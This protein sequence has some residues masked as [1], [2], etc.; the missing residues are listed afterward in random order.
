ML[1]PNVTSYD[2]KCNCG[3]KLAQVFMPKLRVNF[4]GLSHPC[5]NNTSTFSAP[6][7]SLLQ[8][9]S[10]M[11]TRQFALI[12]MGQQYVNESNLTTAQQSD[13]SNSNNA[14][15]GQGNF[16]VNID[17]NTPTST[18]TNVNADLNSINSN[19]QV[20]ANATTSD[21]KILSLSLVIL[22]IF[23]FLSIF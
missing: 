22:A 19:V 17:S 7:P 20:T 1:C 11:K 12:Q 6:L 18:N 14:A 21:S 4:T 23:S 16:T 2:D 15:S 5:Q 10:I 13:L 8:K 9:S 3:A